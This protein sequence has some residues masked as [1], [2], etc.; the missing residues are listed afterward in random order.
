MKQRK[1]PNPPGSF[2]VLAGGFA[3]AA[4][5]STAQSTYSK[6][7]KVSYDNYQ[8]LGDTKSDQV[9]AGGALK[10]DEA[11]LN[12]KL[13]AVE[14]RTDTKFAQLLGK[15]DAMATGI[16]DLRAEI[17]AVKADVADV[18]RNVR[19][20]RWEIV[21]ALITTGLA[22]VG[23]SYAGVQKFQGGMGVTASAYQSGIAAGQAK[24]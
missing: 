7:F 11:L 12:A 24:P 10:M 8:R 15:M 19:Q 17:S 20:R 21:V 9:K 6:P 1:M 4:T 23:L 14:A 16:T 22:I 3:L 18:N 5:I 2:N 13:E